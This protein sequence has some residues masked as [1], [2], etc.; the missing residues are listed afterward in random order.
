MRAR[1]RLRFVLA[2]LAALLAVGLAALGVW[3]IERRAWKLALIARVE[4]RLTAPPVAPPP[5]PPSRWAAIGEEDA[6]TRLR[7]AGRWRAA[8]PVFVQAVTDGGP[9][10]WMLSPLDTARGT[11]LVNRGFV[12]RRDAAVAPRGP[13]VV[14]GL[15]RVTE[16]DGAFL[17]DNDPAA[18]RWYSRDVAAIAHARGL[19]TVAPFFVDAEAAPGVA[20]PRGGLTVVQFRNNHFVYAVTWF[21]LAGL[22]AFFAWRIGRGD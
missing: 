18:D 3:Q 1:R 21:A 10:F 14:T 11:I 17:R 19:G 4:A 16:P 7:V 6:Y 5:P 13:A 8:P 2:A 20:W 12:P 15:L 9:G 22:A